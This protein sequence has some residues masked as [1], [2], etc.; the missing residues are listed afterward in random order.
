MLGEWLLTFVWVASARN[1]SFVAGHRAE[2][3]PADAIQEHI[4]VVQSESVLSGHL[5]R[6]FEG[7]DSVGPFPVE[8]VWNVR[9]VLLLPHD[10]LL[11][12]EHHCDNLCSAVQLGSIVGAPCE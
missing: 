5:L 12:G 3:V 8:R 7:M 2:C 10:Y 6:D 1:A 9:H 11:D 4:D